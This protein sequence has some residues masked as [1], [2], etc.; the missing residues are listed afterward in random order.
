VVSGYRG[1]IAAEAP[2]GWQEG[3]VSF[4]ALR[5]RKQTVRCRPMPDVRP[6]CLEGQLWVEKL[7]EWRRALGIV[8]DVRKQ[9]EAPMARV[10][11]LSRSLI[12]FEKDGTMVAVLEMSQASW[13]AAAVV[14]SVE[15]RPLKKV[16][17]DPSALLRTEG[18]KRKTTMIVA[19]A[20][21]L[22][23]SLWLL[24]T[25]GEVPPGIRLRTAM[26]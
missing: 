13:L 18:G 5:I 22:L 11:D 6:Y 3:K 15:R 2:A 1:L 8:A 26:A 25:L 10:D 16:E 14:P 24:A 12:P 23:V 7:W 20:P 19:L 21:K 9:T 17:P 4:A